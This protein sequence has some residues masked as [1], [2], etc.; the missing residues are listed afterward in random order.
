MSPEQAEGGRRRSPH[1]HLL[2]RG[3]AARAGRPAG[4]RSRGT[5][6]S[7]VLS[8]ILK[9]A[10]RRSPSWRPELPPEL[11]RLIRR[12]LAKEP[13]RRYQ[14]AID[15]RNDLEELRRDLESGVRQRATAHL[16]AGA[17]QEP[18]SPDGVARRAALMAAC[19]LRRCRLSRLAESCRDNAGCALRTHTCSRPCGV[20]VTQQFGPALSSRSRP[21]ANGSCFTASVPI[22]SRRGLYLRSIGRTRVHARAGRGTHRRPSSHL[23]ANGWASGRTNAIWKVPVAGGKPELICDVPEGASGGELGRRRR[24]RVYCCAAE[25]SVSRATGGTSTPIT[26]PSCGQNQN[27]SSLTYCPAAKPLS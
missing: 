10:P 3:A 25:L 14:S 2:A 13:T 15:L 23:T 19:D 5:R 16:T 4:G 20:R 27:T 18:A 26:R 6:T 7:L 22:R 24:D 17:T 21:M 8:A 11:G 12:C 1:G 9:D